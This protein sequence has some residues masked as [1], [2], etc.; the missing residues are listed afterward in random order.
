MSKESGES[1][2]FEF[3]GIEMTA[4]STSSAQELQRI[5]SERMEANRKAYRE[6]PEGIAAAAE[7]ERRERERKEKD[8]AFKALN[9]TISIQP[10]KEQEYAEY[11]AKNDDPYGN[12]TV[13]YAE[14][15]AYLMEKTIPANA[16]SP[17]V[18]RFLVDN[19]DRLSHEADTE[20]ITGFM[21]G[22]AVS[23]LAHFWVHGEELRRWH[24]LKTQIKDEGE[25][26]NESG[27]VLNPAILSIG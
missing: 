11:K 1:V 26:A 2:R 23:G 25:R 20:G 12:A 21:Y 15:W 3:N 24:N 7:S 14:Q 18:T 13:V 19:A 16:T 8:A 5:W 27:T 6:S 22:C 9:V 17:Q 10:G 4:H